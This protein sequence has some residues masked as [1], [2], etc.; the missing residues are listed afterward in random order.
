[1]QF[2][3]EGGQLPSDDDRAG[4]DRR[5]A[6]RVAVAVLAIVA[7]V[8]FMAQNSQSVELEFLVFSVSARLWVGMLITLVLGALL[9][10]GLAMMWARR[11][12]RADE[13]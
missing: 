7:A 13:P 3:R 6:V 12:R 1:M 8:V 2:S 5:R 11:G 9:G 4:V 10:Q